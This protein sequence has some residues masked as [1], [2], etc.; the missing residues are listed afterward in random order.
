MTRM[1]AKAAQRYG[2][3]VRDQTGHAISFFAENPSQYGAT[4]PYTPG[5]VLRRPVPEPGDAG[6]PVGLACSS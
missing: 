6:V 3:I 4:D 2:I 1:M 5:R